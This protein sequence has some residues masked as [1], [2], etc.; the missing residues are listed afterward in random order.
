[1]AFGQGRSGWTSKILPNH[2]FGLKAGHRLGFPELPGA[3]EAVFKLYKQRDWTAPEPARKAFGG[4]VLTVES[5]AVGLRILDF[6]L[7]QVAEQAL[8]FA[9]FG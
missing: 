4:I 2:H 3:F 7:N 6:P 1:M 9:G 5:V 8:E